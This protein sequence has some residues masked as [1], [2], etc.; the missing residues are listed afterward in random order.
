[1]P[2]PR[3]VQAWHK[4]EGGKWAIYVKTSQQASESSETGP[5]NC[6]KNHTHSYF[7]SGF[8]ATNLGFS[9]SVRCGMTRVFDV[10][11]DDT[12]TLTP[13]VVLFN[14][15]T[16]LVLETDHVNLKI[17][18]ELYLDKGTVLIG[19]GETMKLELSPSVVGYTPPG[20]VE[21]T[22][23]L[24]GWTYG[25]GYGHQGKTWGAPDYP[26]HFSVD[27]SND[28]H[29]PATTLYT[30]AIKGVLQG[31]ADEDNGITKH[32]SSDPVV[33]LSSVPPGGLMLVADENIGA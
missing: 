22:W 7:R 21:R 1:M 20:G 24:T 9:F 15:K 17:G 5:F 27:A 28:G 10:S 8:G 32:I 18:D 30:F 19:V 11:T 12:V 31:D 2:P 3:I 16:I 4:S 6:S 29:G 33:R 14:N 26:N 13:K 25:G 23:D